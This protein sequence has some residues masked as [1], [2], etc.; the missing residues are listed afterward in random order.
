[1]DS[2]TLALNLLQDL[3][4][5]LEG[6]GWCS[7]V[8]EEF[9]KLLSLIVVVRRVPADVGRLAIEKV[10]IETKLGTAFSALSPR[11]PAQTRY[12]WQWSAFQKLQ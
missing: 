11:R 1:L 7:L 9:A 2:G 4:N 10:W 5:A 6:L 12:I 3:G 8:V